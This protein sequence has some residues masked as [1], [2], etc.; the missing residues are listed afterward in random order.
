MGLLVLRNADDTV[1]EKASEKTFDRAEDQSP[2]AAE[3][4][5][6]GSEGMRRI[7]ARDMGARQAQAGER[8]SLGAMG[9]D[10]VERAVV[11]DDGIQHP[12]GLEIGR[13]GGAG[14]RHGVHA[15]KAERREFAHETFLG[16]KRRI[17]GDDAVTAFL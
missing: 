13:T 2:G 17:D 7:D 6:H 1:G 12:P 9:M 8:T 3:R 16:A 15:R 11:A 14:H 10:G 4:R 5:V